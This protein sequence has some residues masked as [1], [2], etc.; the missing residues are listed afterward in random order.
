M[1]GNILPIVRLPAAAPTNSTNASDVPTKTG[2]QARDSA[3][4]QAVTA[5]RSGG[6]AGLACGA[7]ASS[8]SSSSESR[9][10]GPSA[11]AALLARARSA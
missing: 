3:C 1:S 7:L 2:T 8:S 11:A 5:S 4:H 6:R 9:R 10:I